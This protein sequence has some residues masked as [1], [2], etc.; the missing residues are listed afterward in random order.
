MTA[1]AVNKRRLR[2]VMLVPPVLASHSNL[3]KIVP[4]SSKTSY[5]RMGNLCGSAATVPS[6]PPTGPPS[7]AMEMTRPAPL[8]PQR[9][10]ETPPAPSSRPPSRTRTRTSS[11]SGAAHPIGTSSQDL[12]TRSRTRSA[13]QPPQSSPSSKSTLPQNPRIRAQSVAAP[14]RSSRSE[15]KPSSSGKSDYVV[16]ESSMTTL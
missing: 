13:P 11:G 7:Q 3:K 16:W 14:K 12:T 4:S 10:A 1:K 15:S 8:P 6:P 5:R 2:A 9:S